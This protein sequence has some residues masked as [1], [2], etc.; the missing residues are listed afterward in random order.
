VRDKFAPPTKRPH[1]GFPKEAQKAERITGVIY[2]LITKGAKMNTKGTNKILL[3]RASR[4][5]KFF[6]LP[7]MFFSLPGMFFSLPGT[8]FSLPGAFFSLPI[9]FVLFVV[10]F[11]PFVI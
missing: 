7:G 10:F 8:F 3:K 9:L 11:V 5:E 2:A 1:R 4:A 6:S